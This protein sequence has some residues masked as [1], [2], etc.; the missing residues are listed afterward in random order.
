METEIIQAGNDESLHQ[1]NG[2]EEVGADLNDIK[3][4][5]CTGEL[6]NH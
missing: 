1:I 3:K 6:W 2:N 4:I 5:K